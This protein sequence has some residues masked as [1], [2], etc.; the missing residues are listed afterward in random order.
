MI[1]LILKETI[2]IKQRVSFFVLVCFA[3]LFTQFS[4]GQTNDN[5]YEISTTVGRFDL[6]E[7][8]AA[9]FRKLSGVEFDNKYFRL[10]QFYQIPTDEQ[11]K[12]WESQGLILTDYLSANTY[13]AS[14]NT[15]FAIRQLQGFVRSIAT[16]AAPFKKEAALFFNGIPSYAQKGNNKAQFTISFY[17]SLDANTVQNDLKSKGV[18]ILQYRDYAN[19]LD[20]ILNVNQLDEITNLPYVQ[21][22]GAQPEPPVKETLDYRNTSSRANFLNTGY[23]GLNYNATGVVIGTG[24]SETFGTEIDFRGRM[25][26]LSTST[27]PGAHKIETT[28]NAGGAGNLNPAN[29]NNAWGATLLSL[30][31]SPDYSAL[32]TSHNL[33]FTNHS[34][35]YS[36][37]GGYDSSARSHDL[38]I[39]SLPNHMVS[40]SAGNSGTEI[41]YAPYAFANWSNITG[42]VKQNKNQIA[43]GALSPDD[44]ITSFSSRGPMYDGRI[45]PQ[46]VIEGSEGTSFAS[47]KAVGGFAIITQVYK[48]KNAGVEPKSSLLR[49]VIMNTADDLGNPGPDYIHGYGK[50]NLRRAYTIVNTNQIIS[51]S[52]ANGVTNAHNITIPA[53]AKQVR[54]MIVW[55]DVAAAVNAN[56]AIVN[57]LNLTL[58]SPSLTV[59]NP[60]V[61]DNTANVVNLSLPATRGVDNLNTIEQVTVDNPDSGTWT[62][63][64]NGFNVPSGPQTYFLVYEFL[65]DELQITY[66]LLNQKF[67]SGE[68]YYLRWDSYGITSTFNLAYE[69]NGSGTWVTI[70]NGYDAT[71]RVYKWI[72][73]TVTGGINSIKFR[74]QRNGLTSLSDVNQIGKIPEN[75]RITKVCAG[76]VNLKWSAVTG[77]TAYKVYKLGAKYMEEVTANITYATNSAMLTSQSTTTSEYY[78]VS[79]ITGSNESQRTLTIEKV[80]GDANCIS[81]NWTGAVSINWFTPGNWSTGAIPTATD[82]VVIPSTPV[83]QPNIAAAGAVCGNITI[84]L[85][86]TLTMNATTGYTLSVANDWINNGTFTRGIGIVDF[87]STTSYQEISGSSTTNFYFLK[88]TK[89]TQDKILEVSSS[90]TLNAASNALQLTS[91]TFK[92]SSNS[93]ITPFTSSI[94]LSSTMGLW[95]NG[96]TINSGNF[97]WTLNTGLLRIS[98]GTTNIGTTSGNSITYLNNGIINVDGG[99]LNVAGRIS[100]N[101]DISIGTFALSEGTVIINKFGSTSTTR[102]PFDMAINT[103]FSFVGGTLIIA[104]ASSNAS[105]YWNLSASS[106]VSGGTLQIGD[107]TTPVNQNIRINST[108]PIYN[109]TVNTTNAP[110][111]QLVSNSLSILNNLTILAGTFDANALDV[112][113]KG[114]WA[115]SGTFIPNVGKVVF[116]GAV[117]QKISGTSMTTFKGLTLNN[118]LGL[119]LNAIVNSNV[120]GQ[121]NLS[122]GVITTGANKLIIT[123]NGSVAR[124]IGHVFGNLQ[125]AFSST[126]LVN[127]FEIGDVAIENYTPINVAF[128]AITTAGNLT[129]T[130]KTGDH[131]NINSSVLI[132]NKSVNRYWTL[133]NAGIV[134]STYNTVLNFL[135][136]DID[137][138]VN[139]LNLRPGNYNSTWVYPTIG[140][141]SSNSIGANGLTT[142]GDF[143]L[144]EALF[145]VNLKL[146]I[147][148]YYDSDINAMR[149][150][151]NNQNG[152][153]PITDVEILTIKLHQPTAP[154]SLVA[155]STGILKT[156]GTAQVSY[157]SLPSGMYY[158]AVKGINM[159][160]TW[161]TTI[162][163]IGILPL[164]YDFTTAATKAFGSN[165]IQVKPSVWAF[166][167]GDVNQDESI[168]LFDVSDVSNDSDNSNFGVIPTDINGDGTADLSDISILSINS[169]TSVYS[170]HP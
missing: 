155:S 112:K 9:D 134:F 164:T 145:T 113:I 130:S 93:T 41:G 152:V 123:S 170:Y 161:T 73:P 96:G 147:E 53:N 105:D 69:L 54:V 39:A 14:I 85:G 79:A 86:A 102:A 121:L 5:K 6:K 151:M 19:Q 88:V 114:N 107:A 78:A 16:V 2:M 122:N 135:T 72:A 56:P 140:A 15:A 117:N 160:E 154:F 138:S 13:F 133:Q 8:K 129:A 66:P 21:F 59:F 90:I 63:N 136:S 159:V 84:N 81:I 111:A 10:V 77:A 83:L 7:F 44:K 115:N 70:V 150:V 68:E 26:E 75:F 34:Y 99:I 110:K 61:L 94:S 91:G 49:A 137:L 82:N 132:S 146:N 38:R 118:S 76:V 125:K 40:Y 67:V 52:V 92:L 48:D 124:T 33:R 131:P 55:P 149:S 28:Q 119:T 158:I 141:M 51:S 60:W 143:Q 162:Q 22:I 106:L 120:D 3:I 30:D 42:Q 58:Q 29:K 126:N 17:K 116:D 165:M 95:N 98:A 1:R 108:V 89:G 11:R 97:S 128:A 47:P 36:I 166:Y 35:G 109:L 4:F 142:F 144:A 23:N 167:S 50:P 65:Y 169:D 37:S 43:V 57:N 153:S 12:V 74:V 45:I 80:V 100:P 104:R 32:Y 25:I 24:E 31:G 27:S 156:D 87:V 148:G 157:A 101:S 64:V 103:N 139:T 168:D 163:S 127:T 62:V 71:S 46:L 18:Q 20:V